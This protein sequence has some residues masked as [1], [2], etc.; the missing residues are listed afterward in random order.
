MVS[1]VQVIRDPPSP[2]FAWRTESADLPTPAMQKPARPILRGRVVEPGG[3]IAKGAPVALIDVHDGV[4]RSNGER[5]LV[6]TDER[7][8]FRLDVPDWARADQVVGCSPR[9]RRATVSTT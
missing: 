7:G 6:R 4:P 9:Q 2:S 1:C 8:R 5:Q 3:A